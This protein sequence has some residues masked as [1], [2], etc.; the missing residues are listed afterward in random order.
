MRSG[1][2]TKRDFIRYSVLAGLTA[3]TATG[4]WSTKAKAAPQQGGTFRGVSM[5]AIRPT[6]TIPVPTSPA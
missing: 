6:R 2:I 3:T 1:G 4:L 5:T